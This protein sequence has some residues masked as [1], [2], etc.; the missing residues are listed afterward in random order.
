MKDS[1]RFGVVA[2][3]ACFL[4]LLLAA[5]NPA[6]ALDPA[7]KCEST[8]VKEAA[9]KAK[10]V[11]IVSAK[12]IKKNEALDSGKLLEKLNKC[13][14]KFD[15]KFA[16]AESKAEGA[17]PTNGDAGT[18]EGLVDDCINDVI[19]SLGGAPQGDFDEVK[20]Q[21]KKAKEAGKYEMCKLKASS[22]AI[23]KGE[24]PD[25]TKCDDK[26]TS[27][28]GKIEAKPDKNPCL[29]P[30]DLS[31][32]QAAL[33][34]CHVDVTQSLTGDPLC[35]NGTLNSGEQCDDGNTT[36]GDGCSDVCT[37][38]SLIEYQQDFELLDQVDGQMAGD[39]WLVWVNVAAP[40]PYGYPISPAPNNVG[41]RIC[42][43]TVAQGGPE[44]GSKQLVVYSD[45]WQGDH[46]NG[47]LVEAN[48][49]QERPIVAGD[50]GRTLT[51]QFDAKLGDIAGASTAI[52]FIKTLDPGFNL[53]DFIT[54]DM[55]AIPTTWGT[56]SVSLDI[57]APRV[58]FILQYG[59]SNTA[60]NW[61]ASG[62]F[63]DNVVASTLPTTP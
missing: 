4:G 51:F 60:S 21:S 57:D 42:D 16:K 19:S 52:G 11:A 40:T 10:C 31:S 62:I 7:V 47:Y 48:L 27:K 22:K 15:D 59:F 25:F 6:S 28:W 53:V 24:S 29:T 34:A 3:G 32:V 55:S 13:S 2:I 30:G 36:N 46:A 54:V 37:V 56:Y 9:K 61:E 63:Y 43:V 5:S 8:K 14:D 1:K 12:S 58:G 38:E 49:Y 26:L 17:C 50:V 44:Q 33:D 20:C 45:Y 35:G 23:K 18:I 41:G 39:G